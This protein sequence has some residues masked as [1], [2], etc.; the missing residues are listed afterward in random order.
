LLVEFV[1]ELFAFCVFIMRTVATL[2]GLTYKEINAIV[3]LIVGPALVLLFFCL[4]RLEKRKS[5]KI[6]RQRKV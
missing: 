4:W 2:T 6:S 1:T 5:E 3:F